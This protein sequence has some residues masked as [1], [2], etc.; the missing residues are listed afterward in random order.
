MIPIFF[1]AVFLSLLISVMKPT[2]IN[3]RIATT[4]GTRRGPATEARCNKMATHTGMERIRSTQL[5]SGVQ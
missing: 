5:D 3:T 2:A 4:S 1:L